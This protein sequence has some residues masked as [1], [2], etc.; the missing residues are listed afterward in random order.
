MAWSPPFR[1]GIFLS[2]FLETFRH[3]LLHALRQPLRFLVL[4]GF[5]K[6]VNLGFDARELLVAGLLLV[7]FPVL[8]LELPQLLHEL[9]RLCLVAFLLRL[10]RPHFKFPRPL[11]EFGIFLGENGS[12]D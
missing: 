11:A 10:L 9:L 2:V 4:A 6:F 8:L 1:V 5:V 12:R 3:R 7:A